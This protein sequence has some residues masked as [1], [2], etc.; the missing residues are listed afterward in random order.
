[1]DEIVN[2]KVI[3]IEIF[4]L[5]EYNEIILVFLIISSWLQK[6]KNR[7][8]SFSFLRYNKNNFFGK[9]IFYGLDRE[10]MVGGN[11]L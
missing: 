4:S 7:I 6:L 11:T 8:V 2:Q 5:Q 9:S 1:M 10:S 3:L